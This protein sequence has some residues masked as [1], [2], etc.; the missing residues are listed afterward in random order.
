MPENRDANQRRARREQLRR[1]RAAEVK[2]LRLRLLAAVLVLLASAAVI[3]AV[4]RKGGAAP[5]NGESGPCHESFRNRRP[6]GGSHGNHRCPV[7]VDQQQDA[8][9]D[10]PTTVI[11]LPPAAIWWSATK[12]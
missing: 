9:P 6:H 2:K 11:H 7:R 10:E 5:Q 3:I 4:S 1:Q 12:R 8:L